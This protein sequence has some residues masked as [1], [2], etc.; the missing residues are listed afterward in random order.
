MTADL[1][2]DLSPR[3]IDDARHAL[4]LATAWLAV[5]DDIM[6]VT[7]EQC[8]RIASEFVRLKA[9][10]DADVEAARREREGRETLFDPAEVEAVARAICLSNRDRPDKEWLL[11]DGR[12][13]IM[14]WQI[15]EG[16]AKAAIAAMREH[17]KGTAR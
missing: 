7:E 9:M 17:S 10:S 15:Y 13:D 1:G 16:D 3:G 11:A 8:T 5:M 4:G 14:G 12:R 6:P 2:E